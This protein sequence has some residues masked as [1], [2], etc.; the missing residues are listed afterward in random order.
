VFERSKA[1]N[2][3]LIPYEELQECPIGMGVSVFQELVEP[4][5]QFMLKQT[6]E[7]RKIG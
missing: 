3:L 5:S 2:Q 6:E 1:R 7:E 4:I